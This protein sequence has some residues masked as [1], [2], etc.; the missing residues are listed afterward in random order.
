MIWRAATNISIQ[1]SDLAK[2]FGSAV[3]YSVT[4]PASDMTHRIIQVMGSV[5][6]L[7]AVALLFIAGFVFSCLAQGG[8]LF[9]LGGKMKGRTPT[10]KESFSVGRTALWPVIAL[11]VII[12][13]VIWILRFLG[14]LPLFFLIRNPS[15]SSFLAHA[16]SFGLSLFLI[17][18][19]MV[20]EIFALCALILQGAHLSDA[21]KRGVALFRKNWIVII[22]TAI[23]QFLIALVIWFIFISL[24]ALALLPIFVFLIS[25]TVL[26]SVVF[27]GI[28]GLL[29]VMV[30][31][32]GLFAL[33]AFT[34]QFQYATWISLFRRLGEGGVVPKLHRL[35]RR[36]TGDTSISQS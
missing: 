12:I 31:F 4:V 33:S 21:L 6:I 23:L 36:V 32:G 22:E 11:N 3:I 18:F 10:L 25:A 8:L 1:G 27:F 20:V 29:G 7:L 5:E 19:A 2:S 15:T 16:L 26:H 13:G 34:V 28:T 30:L 9:A 24:F 35:F 14:S 17:F